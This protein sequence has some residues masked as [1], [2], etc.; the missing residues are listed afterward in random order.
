MSEVPTPCKTV[1]TF[2]NHFYQNFQAKFYMKIKFTQDA[3]NNFPLHKITQGAHKNRPWYLRIRNLK[4]KWK[5]PRNQKIE[6][7]LPPSSFKTSSQINKSQ[8][9]LFYFRWND[10][11]ILSTEYRS[12]EKEKSHGWHMR[13]CQLYCRSY[14]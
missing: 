5:K 6:L 9:N 14:Q 11:L 10:A 12:V 7:H 13:S 4:K 1:I 2:H 3:H 8:P